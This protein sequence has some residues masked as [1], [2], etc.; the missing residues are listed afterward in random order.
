MFLKQIIKYSLSI[1]GSLLLGITLLLICSAIIVHTNIK[2]EYIALFS[3]IINALCVMT[4]SFIYTLTSDFKGI[5]CA[6]ISFAIAI[7]IKLIITVIVSGTVSITGQGVVNI[8]S[9][10]VF[11]VIGSTVA[12]N[13]KK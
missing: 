7:V 10:M 1:F 6:M 3:V 2:M 5:Y 13:I 12:V 4:L 9:S 11:S 8:L